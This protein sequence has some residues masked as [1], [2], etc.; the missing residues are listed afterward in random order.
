M[1]LPCLNTATWTPGILA[2]AFTESRQRLG[3][4]VADTIV[5]RANSLTIQRTPDAQGTV[6]PLAD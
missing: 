4:L 5:I 1:R 3:D 2:I 6:T